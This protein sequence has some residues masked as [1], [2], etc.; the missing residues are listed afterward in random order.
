MDSSQGDEIQIHA[1]GTRN[2]EVSTAGGE[3]EV[4]GD[5]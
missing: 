4:E 3:G 5:G 2:V 1:G